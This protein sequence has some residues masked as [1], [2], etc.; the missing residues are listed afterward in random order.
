MRFHIPAL[1]LASSFVPAIAFATPAASADVPTTSI[2]VSTGVTSPVLLN[3]SQLSISNQALALVPAPSPTVEL[4]LH[5]DEKGAPS[6]VRVV[7][8]VSPNVD[9][10]VVTAARAFHFRP[11]MLDH[12][13]VGMNMRVKVI[14]QR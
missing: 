13:P 5:V 7:K 4:S 12:Q 11:A 14:I 10:Q 8:S 1:L 9:A 6:D 3:G 2:L